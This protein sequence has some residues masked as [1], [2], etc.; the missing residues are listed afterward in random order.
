MKKTIEKINKMKSCFF[1]KIHKIDKPL[2]RLIKQKRERTQMNKTR[3]EKGE[4]TTDITEIQKIIRDFYM[5]P[6]ANKT[7]DLEE[8][9]KCLEKYNLPR[10]NPDEIEKMNGPITRPEIETWLKNFQQTKVPDQMA[11]Q[12]NSI[13]QLKKSSHLSF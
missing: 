3:S 12:A 10:L 2:A 7:D 13:K 6:Y 8:M 5:Q 9:D 11:S 4:V 1:E